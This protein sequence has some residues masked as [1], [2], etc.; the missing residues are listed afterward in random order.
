M[1]PPPPITFLLGA[2]TTASF[3]KRFGCR[4]S[5]EVRR[6]E[7]TTIKT[8]DNKND[9][10]NKARATKSTPTGGSIFGTTLP[11]LKYFDLG[12]IAGRGGYVRYWFLAHGI[13][14]KEERVS[15]D[16]WPSLKLKLI[17][18]GDNPAGHLPVLDIGGDTTLF[19]HLAMLRYLSRQFGGYGTDSFL[20]YE[21]D[22]AADEYR[23]WID[24]YAATVVHPSI[25]MVEQYRASRAS[26]YTVIEALYA[27]R[28]HQAGPF[29][30]LSP[31]FV[32]CCVFGLIRDDQILHGVIDLQTYPHMQNMFDEFM[33]IPSVEAW[34]KAADL[35]AA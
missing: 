18:S 22:A 9:E 5:T 23:S 26:W 30:A 15:F 21:V 33:K 25:E 27:K 1:A 4:R 13:E 35:S 3:T 14:F 28:S 11:V 31:T 12:N 29:F 17:E 7:S 6:A 10:K 16:E 34:I 20:D 8:P 19:D 32:D 2:I 24:A